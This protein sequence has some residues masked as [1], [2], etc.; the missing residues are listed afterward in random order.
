MLCINDANRPNPFKATDLQPL[1]WNY[2]ALTQLGK[3]PQKKAVVLSLPTI[4]SSFAI[5]AS[6]AFTGFNHSDYP[7]LRT[8]LE[9]LDGTESFLWVI[10]L[11]FASEFV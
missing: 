6:Q 2:E 11:I 9:V 3:Q 10:L 1:R 7:A 8:A 5:H 4:E